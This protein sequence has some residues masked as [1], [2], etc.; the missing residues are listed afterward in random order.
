MAGK[1]I[2]GVELADLRGLTEDLRRGQRAAARDR[3]QGRRQYGGSG[4]DLGGEFIKLD[5]E[6]AEMVDESGRE[7]GHQPGESPTHAPQ[8]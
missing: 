3:Q 8:L 4:G 1:C 5:R 2:L 7:V 6:T